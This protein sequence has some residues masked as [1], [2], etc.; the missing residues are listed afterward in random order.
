MLVMFTTARRITFATGMAVGLTVGTLLGAG[1][2]HAAPGTPSCVDD[3]LR[4]LPARQPRGRSTGLLQRP[5]PDG[6]TVALLRRREPRRRGR[7]VRLMTAPHEPLTTAQLTALMAKADDMVEAHLFLL[8][9]NPTST[10]D[11]VNELIVAIRR[12]AELTGDVTTGY[13]VTTATL[14]ATA[15]Q[16]L[17]T[18]RW[19]S[20]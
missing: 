12:A 16:K 15:L 14:L 13:E 2:A 7:G 5:R 19:A 11:L 17:A 4:I 1:L 8:T 6:R 20:R 3:G 9:M 10:P 18:E